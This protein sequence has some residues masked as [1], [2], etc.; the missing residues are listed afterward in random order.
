MDY[1]IK[2]LKMKNLD[3][4]LMK[5]LL[6]ILLQNM[7]GKEGS[8]L[9][10]VPTK[11]A[12]LAFHLF[13]EF[14]NEVDEFR[15]AVSE[16]GATDLR[17][18]LKIHRRCQPRSKDIDKEFSASILFNLTSTFPQF[19]DWRELVK[20]REHDDVEQ[21]LIKYREKFQDAANIESS[22]GLSHKISSLLFPPQC[23]IFSN[24]NISPFL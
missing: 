20:E 11:E 23:T 2:G 8:L 16:K 7:S 4:K 1:R 15:F 18:A 19:S 17:H 6:E 22:L 21:V 12:D 5:R 9:K 13:A 10:Q 14:L 24:L 3:L